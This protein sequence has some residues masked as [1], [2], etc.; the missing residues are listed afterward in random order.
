MR[1]KFS[2]LLIIC[3][4][5]F[6]LSK[7]QFVPGV[8]TFVSTPYGNIPIPTYYHMPIAYFSLGSKSSA[9]NTKD[10]YMIKLK[11]D[12]TIKVYAEIDFS[13]SIHALVIKEKRKIVRKIAPSETK[14]IVALGENNLRIAGNPN[15]SCW[16]FKQLED[17]VSLYS[18]VPKIGTEYAIFFS[19]PES[20]ELI[21][22][23]EA[24]LLTLVGNDE[25]LIELI[26]H[27]NYVKAV[28][29]YNSMLKQQTK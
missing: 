18:V 9:I 28:K 5:S 21:I 19:K 24:N 20:T 6:F 11:N 12:S 14:Y 26:T 29:K 16:T 25:K 22:L 27:K 2:L 13:D 7:A 3:C 10:Y 8:P 4:C 1:F 17:S 15:D 23:N